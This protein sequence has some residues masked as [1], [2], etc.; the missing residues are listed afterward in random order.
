MKLSIMIW[1]S[2]CARTVPDLA[3]GAI[4]SGQANYVGPAR[5]TFDPTLSART[6]PV[7]NAEI[8]ENPV[9]EEIDD[10]SQS[11]EELAAREGH[12]ESLAKTRQ[13]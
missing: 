7:I 2:A 12:W 3:C 6:D 11:Y 10:S 9:L 8:I 4:E 13:A 5:L 1:I